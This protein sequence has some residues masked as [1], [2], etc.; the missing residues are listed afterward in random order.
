MA[1]EDDPP[2]EKG[3][4][5]QRSGGSG[6][7]SE[8][9][10]FDWEQESAFPTP[11]PKLPDVG[12]D[13]TV[14]MP[15]PPLPGSDTPAAFSLPP[16]PAF[17]AEPPIVKPVPPPAPLKPVARKVGPKR[18]APG[19]FASGGSMKSQDAATARPRPATPAELRARQKYEQKQRELEEARLEAEEKRHKRNRRLIG[20]GVGVGV[21][22]VVVGLGY[23]AFSAPTVMAQCVRDD[24]NGQPVIVPDS[25]CT[26]HTSGLNGFF[27]YGGHQYR[28]YYG[29]SGG[30]GSRPIGGTTTRPSGATIKTGSGHTIQRGGLGGKMGGGGS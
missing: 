1:S 14:A 15:L 4:P 17:G 22:G 6:Q 12:A 30:I 20:A 21:V 3:E 26:G 9:A 25:Y 18:D 23:W 19:E 8:L 5:G 10:S 24:P 7:E 28:Y 16:V 11:L 29:S 27:F 13:P 2:P